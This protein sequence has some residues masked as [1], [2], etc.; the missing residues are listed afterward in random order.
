MSNPR[1]EQHQ[2]DPSED[3]GESDLG[4]IVQLLWRRRLVVVALTFAG[5]ALALVMTARQPR[6]HAARAS[7][8]LDP[9]P[10]RFLDNAV[11]EVQ[12]HES[13]GA[14]REFMGTQQQ[15]ILSRSVANRVV[16]KL[17]LDSDADFLGMPPG[18]DPAVLAGIDAAGRL[19]GALS[20][21]PQKDT[22]I[23]HLE[24]RDVA[25]ERAA[26]L[27]NEVAEAYI[28][29][30]L[31]LRLEASRSASRWL[32]ARLGELGQKAHQSELAV[33]DFKREADVLSTSLDNR[34]SIV[35]ERLGAYS[36]SLT[37]VRTEMAGLRGKLESMEQ[38]RKRAAGDPRW[39]EPLVEVSGTALVHKLRG[40][41]YETQ[42]RCALLALRFVSD[43]PDVVACEKQRQLLETG[44][45]RELENLVQATRTELAE[46]GARERHLV[47]LLEAAKNE[48]F[49]LNRKQLSFERLERDATND[50]RLHDVVFTRLKDLELSGLVRTSHVRMLDPARPSF[51][52]ISPK[53][54]VNLAMGLLGGFVVAAGLVVALEK[55]DGRL[56]LQEDVEGLLRAP[57]LGLFPRLTSR[58]AGTRAE[59]DL[60]VA[61][62]PGSPAAEYCRAI[63]TNLLF[64]TPKGASRLVV[65]TSGGLDEGKSTLTLN[66]GAALAQSGLRTLIVDADLRRPRLH[67][68]LGADNARGVST[69]SAGAGVLEDAIQRTV[70]P[71]L[72]LLP[73]G[74][75][76]PQ[77]AELLHTRAFS[78]L[79]VRLGERFDRVLIDSPPVN[80][81]ADA[82]VLAAQSDGVILVIRANQTRREA[83]AKALRTLQNVKAQ[84]LGLVLNAADPADGSPSGSYGRYPA[85]GPVRRPAGGRDR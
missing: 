34:L 7:I 84:V 54:P 17:G 19:L 32:E 76:P 62:H 26:L 38:L 41:L 63:R 56:R 73:G 55:R 58:D 77:P 44:V 15:V 37:A 49:E 81:V 21:H 53:V 43:H 1:G 78:E 68:A 45:R 59:R 23:L 60:L 75:L 28:E 70:V 42:S 80:L 36:S 22:R 82:A 40:E 35:S 71:G 29:Q 79:L 5:L 61:G 66:L 30:T 39:A 14:S 64:A 31:E 13:A 2:V 25:P 65:V 33:H 20:V 10:P 46:A 48:A 6:I 47:A 83:A 16:E 11:Q 4:W 52:P 74:P 51:V 9:A 8:V 27:A 12:P 18:T 50:R 24:V 3:H 67:E 85:P 57:L 72:F 69:L